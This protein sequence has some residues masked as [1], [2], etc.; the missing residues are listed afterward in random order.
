MFCQHG[1]LVVRAVLLVAQS[2]PH[3]GKQLQSWTPPPATNVLSDAYSH[4]T[5]RK[6][7]SLHMFFFLVVE[8]FSGK[9][10]N[11]DELCLATQA[12]TAQ[13][14]TCLSDLLL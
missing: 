10:Q 13:L 8:I 1:D 4:L 3:E 5:K 6:K 12:C 9:R 2:N 11:Y 7:K 14:E